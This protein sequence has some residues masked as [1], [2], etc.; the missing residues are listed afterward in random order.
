V[1]DQPYGLYDRVLDWFSDHRMEMAKGFV[2][3]AVV[4]IFAS[5]LFA[6]LIQL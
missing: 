3:T 5:L 2:V 4:A 1:A 6:I